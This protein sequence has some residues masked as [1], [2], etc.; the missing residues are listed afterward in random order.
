[1]VLHSKGYIRIKISKD[2]PFYVMSDRGWILEHRYIMANFLGRILLPCED[3]HHKE[4][5]KTNNALTNLEHLYHVNHSHLPKAKSKK[6][7][8]EQIAHVVSLRIEHGTYIPWNKGLTKETDIRVNDLANQ[9]KEW[10][11]N[12]A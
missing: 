8:P 9:K 10:W 5:P 7:T 6:R 2:D 12:Q 1:M 4:E 11:V 3:V